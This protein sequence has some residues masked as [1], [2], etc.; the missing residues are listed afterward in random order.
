MYRCVQGTRKCMRV[1]GSVCTCVV[2]WSFCVSPTRLYLLSFAIPDWP[3]KWPSAPG[4]W[5]ESAGLSKV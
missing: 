5:D 4:E 3:L 1:D 2:Y